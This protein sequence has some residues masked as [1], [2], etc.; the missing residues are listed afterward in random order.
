MSLET[1][2]VFGLPIPCNT[3]L[4]PMTLD[5]CRKAWRFWG[6]WQKRGSQMSKAK[7]MA[8]QK[9]MWPWLHH[10]ASLLPRS[11]KNVHG[12]VSIQSH[13]ENSLG[14][15]PRSILERWNSSQSQSLPAPAVTIFLNKKGNKS[16]QV[17]LSKKNVGD[18]NRIRQVHR[19]H[20]A[21]G[22]NPLARRWSENLEAAVSTKWIRR[23]PKKRVI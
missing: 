5:S 16:K 4:D 2:C 18:N 22:N 13:K 15:S 1:L 14:Q 3:I 10:I 7:K 8:T 17:K 11:S 23:K 21:L 19:Y 12:S 6:I 9:A 20:K